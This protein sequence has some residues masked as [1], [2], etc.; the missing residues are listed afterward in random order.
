MCIS[1]ARKMSE[2]TK[3]QNKQISKKYVSVL[4][5][6]VKSAVESMKSKI[7]VA[8]AD[9]VQ[10]LLVL[11]DSFE[12]QAERLA[13]VEKEKDAEIKKLLGKIEFTEK[14]LSSLQSRFLVIESSK[15]QCQAKLQEVTNSNVS[16]EKE[17]NELLKI[18]GGMKNQERL[19]N[20][21]RDIARNEVKKIETKLADKIDSLK[22]SAQV[23]ETHK[24]EIKNLKSSMQKLS[25][26]LIEVKKI[27]DRYA[28]DLELSATTINRKDAQLL[29]LSDT[30]TKSKAAQ[31]ACRM[32][33]F[34]TNRKLDASVSECIALKRDVKLLTKQRDEVEEERQRASK[35]NGELREKLSQTETN[36]NEA[37]KTIEQTKRTGNIVKAKLE[38]SS[39]KNDE[40]NAL[41]AQKLHDI[42]VLNKAVASCET[43]IM[44]LLKKVEDR[45]NE[46]DF[47]GS[48]IIRRNDEIAM[49]SEKLEVTQLALDRGESQYDDRMQD[50]RV[51]QVESNNLKCTVD[52]MKANAVK[53]EKCK[54]EM[55]VLRRELEQTKCENAKLLEALENPINIHRWRLLE[56]QDPRRMELIRKVQMLQKRILNQSAV[57]ADKERA[58]NSN[59][60]YNPY[61]MSLADTRLA[62]MNDKLNKTRMTLN[63]STRRL[64]SLVAE[65]R[66]R[67]DEGM[68]EI[69][70]SNV[71]FEPCNGDG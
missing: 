54:N 33:A 50:I 29:A 62:S 56:G 28:H 14:G 23:L 15:G 44:R 57:I 71:T 11:A 46:K 32:Q 24:T 53:M 4:K 52:V 19:T 45:Q 9:C 1:N 65:N 36:L 21:E 27:R 25:T 8:E 18:I 17:K 12:K 61:R 69:C 66:A 20:R 3:N 2:S 48:Q 13:G 47:I 70:S 64:K 43:S 49:L 42:D 41:I 22:V 26:E 38:K 5:G 55:A 35:E 34:D 37:H 39:A 60:R 16:L 67:R 51:L 58:L 59:G 68:P 6:R 10:E 7:M 31:E 30:L 63:R 40:L